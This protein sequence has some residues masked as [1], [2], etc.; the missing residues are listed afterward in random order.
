MPITGGI[1]FTG[2]VSPTDE[3]DTYPVTKPEYGAGGLRR[4]SG[5]SQRDAIFSAR[6]EEGMMVY[7]VSNQTYYSLIGGTANA[8]WTTLYVDQS[9]SLGVSGPDGAVSSIANINLH[10]GQNMTI[11]VAE[12]GTGTAGITFSVINIEA[13]TF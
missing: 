6:R 1:Q 5:I 4:V 10:E 11:N 12:Q 3:A 7:V 9:S 2:F 13:G 8:N